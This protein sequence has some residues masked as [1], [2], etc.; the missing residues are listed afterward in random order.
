MQ[1]IVMITFQ[2]VSFVH[3]LDKGLSGLKPG[4]ESVSDCLL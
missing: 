1:C 4:Q 2:T 3:D